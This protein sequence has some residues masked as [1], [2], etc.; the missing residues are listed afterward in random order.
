MTLDSQYFESYVPVY[1]TVPESWEE[2]K[3]FL[4]EQLKKI[5]MAVNARE[6]GWYLDEELLSGKAFIPS[7]NTSQIGDISQRY[8]SILRKVV[9][10]GALPNT[11]SKAAL[12][13][14]DITDNFT[15]VSMS[16][17]A[18]DPINLM[19]LPIP[20]LGIRM[21]MDSTNINITTS[22]DMTSYTRCFVIIEYIQEL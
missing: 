2:A 5:A 14:I 1:D 8:R 3:P 19:S 10:F 17:C 11:G 13:G 20:N 4:V 12:H 18:T 7:T 16:A 9:E 6:I 22:N 15:L 21:N